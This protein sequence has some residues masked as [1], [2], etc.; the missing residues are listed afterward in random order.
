MSG[1]MIGVGAVVLMAGAVM[2]GFGIP[3]NEFSFGNTLIVAGTTA[4]VG[5]LIVIG[6]GFVMA[7]LQRIAE[8]MADRTP[9]RSSQSFDRFEPAAEPGGPAPQDHVPFPTRPKAASF[10]PPP[11]FAPQTGH[12]AEGPVDLD[13]VALRHADLRHAD[14]DRVDLAQGELPM[15]PPYGETAVPALRNPDEPPVTVDDDVSLSPRH[16]ISTASSADDLSGHDDHNHRDHD[17]RRVHA[18][19]DDRADHGDRSHDRGDSDPDQRDEDLATFAEKR[20]APAIDS[21]WQSAPPPAFTSVRQ[22]TTYFDSMWPAPAKKA[23]A[24]VK[25]EPKFEH[26]VSEPANAAESMP[27]HDDQPPVAILKSGVV[28]GMAYTL[29]VDGSIEAELPDGTLRF[30]SI[31]ELREHLELNP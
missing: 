29:Y 16:P 25:A 19:H 26:E 3:I 28:D 12:E 7:Q 27:P 13:N 20:A 18:D 30:A 4:A 24:E 1:L 31:K 5:G 2:I 9:I 15:E 23:A 8:A 21:D 14:G 17:D 11:A 10:S 22:P 6:L